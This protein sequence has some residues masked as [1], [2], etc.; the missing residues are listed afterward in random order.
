MQ[1]ILFRVLVGAVA[2]A[3]EGVRQSLAGADLSEMGQYAALAGV[4]AALVVSALGVLV[5]KYLTDK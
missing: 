2:A 5:K 3:I 1:K 4:V